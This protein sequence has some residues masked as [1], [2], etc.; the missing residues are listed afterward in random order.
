MEVKRS[1]AQEWQSVRLRDTFCVDD[2]IRV[3]NL[4]RAA[5]RIPGNEAVIRLDEYTTLT[6]K[7]PKGDRPFWLQLLHG[8]LHFLSP[9]PSQLDIDTPFVSA[10][11]EGTE[12]VMRVGHARTSI[13]VFEGTVWATNPA[14]SVRLERGEGAAAGVN[15]APERRLVAKPRDAVQW[16]LYYPP[17]IDYPTFGGGPGVRS[18]PVEVA[19][20]LYRQGNVAGAVAELDRVVTDRRD[21]RFYDLRAALLLTVG[22]VGGARRD[23]DLALR[24]KPGDAVAISLLS[25]I[26][27]VKNDKEMALRLARQAV[28]LDPQGPVAHIAL[29]YAY[30]ADFHLAKA[31]A[32]VRAAIRLAPQNALA[33]ARLAELRLSRGDGRRALAAARKAVALDPRIARTQTVL[34]FARLGQ[35]QVKA[36]KGTF[37][38]AI[39]LDP[40]D[41]LPRLGLGLAKIRL[42]DLAG[43]IE[44]IQIATSLDPNQSLIR[45]YLGKAYYEEGRDAKAGTT[46]QEA[47]ALDPKDP[48]PWFYDAI[49]KQTTNRPVEALHELQRSIALNDNRA[50]Y[51]SRLL[52][53]EDLA[54][55]S[56]SLGRIYT[57]LG[58]EQA[59]LVEAT[60]SLG[61]DPAE[62]SAHRLL[63]D[64]Y[65]DL[66]R[67][68]LARGSE[69]LQARLL[70]PINSNPV[71][72]SRAASAFNIAAGAGPS[73]TGFNEFSPLFERNRWRL[74]TSMFGGNN[75]TWGDEVVL[76]GLYDRWGA[77]LGQF[78]ADTGGF[79]A[80]SDAESDLYNAFFQVA[81]TPAL[82]VQAEYQRHESEAGDLRLTFTSPPSFRTRQGFRQDS[83]RIGTHL[84]LSPRSDIIFSALYA[85]T[86]ERQTFSEDRFEGTFLEEGA[87]FEVESQYLF[88]GERFNLTAGFGIYETEV[89]RSLTV[90]GAGPPFSNTDGFDRK[91][92]SAY[93]YGNLNWPKALVW[94]IGVS[95]D[96]L[97]EGD[98]DVV[99]AVN[100]KLG[101]Q[102]DLTQS[103]RLRAAFVETGKQALLSNQ[104]IEPSEV[105]G[106]NQFFDDLPGTEARRYGAGLDVRLGEALYA[107]IEGSR[108][109]LEVPFFFIGGE[110]FDRAEWKE[111][112]YRGYLYWTPSPRWAASAEYRL[113]TF[114][115]KEE[116]FPGLTDLDTISVPLTIR[117]FHPA[118][119]FARLGATYVRQEIAGLSEVPGDGRDDFVVVD[120]AL[121]Y[122][123][124]KRL[125][126]MS[127]GV[128]N[129][130]DEE[131]RFQDDSFRSR[132]LVSGQDPI[133]GEFRGNFG[134]VPDRVIF[135]AITLSF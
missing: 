114:E 93:L 103:I 74:L 101:L 82:N 85:G 134:F 5:I 7:T 57:D 25:V 122:R 97:D 12:L 34:G 40:V 27:L 79:R 131:F 13:W 1:S 89:D 63:S 108:R 44:D 9:G 54:T 66:P 37:E 24:M 123:L 16:A 119:F 18:R 72:P 129:L 71:R 69:L 48:T 87:G 75:S 53:D 46:L 120:A 128:R 96:A 94:T 102:W 28:E 130:L 110:F 17:L 31:L 6:F 38:R 35:T 14:G 26:A 39:E 45:S 84:K 55:R 65:V 109:D 127:L 59:G 126:I 125:G 8:V 62:D 91:R 81:V 64:T 23:I 29:S 115:A 100:P 41:P 36:A 2:S 21:A 86:E 80:N 133:P 132:T 33:R 58:F 83:G 88:R 49:F 78:H 116:P 70:Q 15:V 30:Q 111:E 106:F 118:G 32:R 3:G 47:K 50:V 11:I 19:L 104:S 56:T 117:Y 68:D 52:L 105:A 43:G 76:S 107:G 61:L 95:Y 92:H 90:T 77:S 99:G 42:G 113:D 112:I 60:K 4:S 22:R 20:A 98:T 10:Q 121:G 135:T 51:R 73:N 67:H 124:P